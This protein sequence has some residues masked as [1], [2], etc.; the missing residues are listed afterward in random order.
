VPKLLLFLFLYIKPAIWRYSYLIK[1]SHAGSGKYS[2]SNFLF[3]KIAVWGGSSTPFG[4]GLSFLEKIEV[5]N[6]E[7][8]YISIKAGVS[9]IFLYSLYNF[10]RVTLIKIDI[11]SYVPNNQISVVWVGI[12]I[13]FVLVHLKWFGVFHLTIG[14]LRIFGFNAPPA[15]N[16]AFLSETFV[17]FWNRYYYYF[18]ELMVEFF[19][20]P[21]FFLFFKKNLKLRTAFATFMAAGVG[22]YYYHFL[23]RT[24]YI[25]S[26]RDAITTMIYCILLAS[27]ISISQYRF[28]T[29]KHKPN[30]KLLVKLRNML[31]VVVTFFFLWSYDR[32]GW[33][34]FEIV[35]NGIL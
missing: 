13:S 33:E 11:L 12:L 18:K 4:K 24:L 19:F 16:K 25:N 7:Q 2:F 1:D 15:T 30:S 20:Y 3:F 29:G 23:S 8:L 22:N 9:L 31:L 10:I 32:Y 34:P 27:I 26:D 17:N 28:L 14:L 5:K 6:K 35:L 21:T